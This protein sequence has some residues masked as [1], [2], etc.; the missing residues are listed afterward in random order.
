MN[1]AT[2]YEHY[3]IPISNFAVCFEVENANNTVLFFEGSKYFEEIKENGLYFCSRIHSKSRTIFLKNYDLL[4]YRSLASCLAYDFFVAEFVFSSSKSPEMIA[5]A[6]TE[7][8]K[9]DV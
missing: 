7:K 5:Q 2:V 9:F 8:Y 4:N 6:V 1:L 3:K